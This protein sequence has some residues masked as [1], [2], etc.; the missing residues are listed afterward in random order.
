[1]LAAELEP[2][3]LAATKAAPEKTLGRCLVVAKRACMAKHIRM[4]R[5]DVGDNMSNIT[6]FESIRLT[7]PPRKTGHLPI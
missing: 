5:Y 4:E 7:P 6:T 2:S 1:V 3:N